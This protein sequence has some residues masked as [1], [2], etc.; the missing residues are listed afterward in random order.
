M[1]ILST[2]TSVQD[3]ITRDRYSK[4]KIRVAAQ[5]KKHMSVV[6]NRDV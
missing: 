3:E 6:E 2:S 5:T 4:E 1:S